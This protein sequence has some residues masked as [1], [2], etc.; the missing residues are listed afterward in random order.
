M[1]ASM[2]ADAGVVDEPAG[3]KRPAE[4]SGLQRLPLCGFVLDLAAGELLT[5]DH[6][7]A[8]CAGRRSTFC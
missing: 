4:A 1:S 2:S 3:G 7:L 5:A 8:G 6:Q